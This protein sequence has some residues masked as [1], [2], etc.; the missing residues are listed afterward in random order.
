[1]NVS[2]TL[3]NMKIESPFNPLLNQTNNILEAEDILPIS[4][5]THVFSQRPL[6]ECITSER[7]TKVSEQLLQL[8]ACFVYDLIN[9]A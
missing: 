3:K 2:I 7:A 9:W 5:P 6:L 1:M 4:I 8:A